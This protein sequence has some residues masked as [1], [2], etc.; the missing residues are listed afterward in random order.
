MRRES[1]KNKSS[2]EKVQQKGHLFK[3]CVPIVNVTSFLNHYSMII[4]L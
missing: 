4:C 2:I 3:E 1:K